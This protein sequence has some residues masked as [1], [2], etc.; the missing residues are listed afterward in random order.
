MN[1]ELNAKQWDQLPGLGTGV[2]SGIGVLDT[3]RCMC[4][5]A[6]DFWRRS[7]L[8]AGSGL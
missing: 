5:H 1:A 6:R 7:M 4:S 2:L 8:E 3:A